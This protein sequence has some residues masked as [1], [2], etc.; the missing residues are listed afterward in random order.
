MAK[1]FLIVTSRYYKDISASLEQGAIA[2]LKAVGAAYDIAEVP[3]ALEIPTAIA[4]ACKKKK[5]Y[6]GYIAIGCVIRGETS[7]YDIVAG[8]SARGLNE[9]AMKKRLPIGNAILTVENQQQAQVRANPDEL[10]KGGFAAKAAMQM[11]EFK[12]S[13]GA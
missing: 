9:L 8:E 10:D 7:H 5:T 4:M 3:G 11:L 6:D 2:A 13:L 1:K 12:Q